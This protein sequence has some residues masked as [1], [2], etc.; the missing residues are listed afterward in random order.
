MSLSR[1]KVGKR[2]VSKGLC[3][4]QDVSLL[5]SVLPAPVSGDGMWSSHSPPLPG[6][7]SWVSFT[8][9]TPPSSTLPGMHPSSVQVRQPY[10]FFTILV[11]GL[12]ITLIF[13]NQSVSDTE[14][15]VSLFVTQLYFNT[16]FCLI[17]K[18]STVVPFVAFNRKAQQYE[19]WP[20][21]QRPMRSSDSPA[22]TMIRGRSRMSRDSIIST[23]SKPSSQTSQASYPV[24]Q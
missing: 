9:D 2:F 13:P 21:Q 12:P 19:R 17:L 24:R 4:L 10:S 18:L 20:R 11:L 23:S 16:S 14:D 7:E 22:A 5:L 3:N 15:K 8:A 1:I 6:Q